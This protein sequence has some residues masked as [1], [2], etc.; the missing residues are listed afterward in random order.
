MQKLLCYRL[1]VGKKWILT[2]KSI[3]DAANSLSLEIERTRQH[4]AQLEQALAGLKPLLAR[5]DSTKLLPLNIGN[6]NK[7]AIDVAPLKAHVINA[8][9]VSVKPST[10]KKRLKAEV[11]IKAPAE[12]PKTGS[13]L[14][15][16][17]VGKKKFTLV[18]LVDLAIKKLELDDTARV[19]IT[20]RA[21]AWVYSSI[22]KGV[23][24]T[25]GVRD[26]VKLFIR[27]PKVAKENLA[28]VPSSTAN[29]SEEMTTAAA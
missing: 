20:N 1:V 4:L 23:L 10:K 28:E 18:E 29:P 14:W 17:C 15:L 7:S 22:K 8:E 2:M 3:F 26:G 16:G 11:E 12:L 6:F 25:A 13:E 27:T 21:G 19:V 24:T 5:A 9:T